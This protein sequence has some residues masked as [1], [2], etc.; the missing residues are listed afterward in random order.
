MWAGLQ[1]AGR[2]S[3]H[4]HAEMTG[5]AGASA[6][7]VG[8]SSLGDL[9]C[10]G[11]HLVLQ[12]GAVLDAAAAGGPGVARGRGRGVGCRG[13]GRFSPPTACRPR[14]RPPVFGV[15]DPCPRASHT[16]H[17]LAPR[18]KGQAGLACPAQGGFHG[19]ARLRWQ[20]RRGEALR[21]PRLLGPSV[22]LW[23]IFR[24]VQPPVIRDSP[25]LPVL[26]VTPI[27]PSRVVIGESFLSLS[28]SLSL[29]PLCLP[30]IYLSSL[31]STCE[32]VYLCYLP[33]IYLPSLSSMSLCICPTYLASAYHHLSFY[34]ISIHHLS[35][36]LPISLLT[37]LL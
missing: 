7:Q 32:C 20:E 37:Y 5:S 14:P 9:A 28:S 29:S 13:T 23:F 22:C 35:T 31:P 17:A 4:R 19:D 34:V 21:A 3:G 10:R 18:S 16:P 15:G 11:R 27:S 12:T 36:Y 30:V 1:E 26:P 8:G 2:R 24:P 6:R 25:L 33:V